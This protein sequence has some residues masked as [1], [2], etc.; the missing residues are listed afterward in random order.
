M[1]KYLFM[2][3]AGL[4][5]LNALIPNEV[6]A[7]SLKAVRAEIPFDF[8]IGDKIH[9]AGVYR[10]ESVSQTSENVLQ[11]RGVGKKNRRLLVTG[12]L[13]ADRWESPKLVF[14]RIGEEYYLM[15]I[16]IAEG[17]SGFSIRPPRGVESGK[18]LAST[19]RVEVPVKN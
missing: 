9:P 18:K 3:I 6:S 1:K 11:L 14:Y 7:Q 13:Y 17:S 15:N 12:N 4:I 8:R 16:F 5:L 19:K 2:F 10:L